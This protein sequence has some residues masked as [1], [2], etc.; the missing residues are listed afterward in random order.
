MKKIPVLVVC[1]LFLSNITYANSNKHNVVLDANQVKIKI[2][3]MVC[4]FCAFGTRKNLSKLKFLNPTELNKGVLLDIYNQQIT[5]AIAENENVDLKQIYESI[6]KGGY[7]PEMVYLRV[8]GNIEKDNIVRD[9]ENELL[10]YLESEKLPKSGS[11]EVELHFD[12]KV[13]PSISAD[14][15]IKASLDRIIE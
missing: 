4:S 15:P 10:F 2:K 14:K 8:K 1:F 11:V 3:G 13:I 9:Q 7:E 5:L 6:I 12:A